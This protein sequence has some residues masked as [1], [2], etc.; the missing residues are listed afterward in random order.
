MTINGRANVGKR[1]ERDL[2]AA[3]L[4]LPQIGGA[5]MVVVPQ[6]GNR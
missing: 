4:R 2:G 3:L 5:V 1:V 6:Q